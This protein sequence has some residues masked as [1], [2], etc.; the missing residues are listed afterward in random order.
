LAA[1]LRFRRERLTPPDVGLPM[2]GRRRP[3]GLRREE[4]AS[5]ASVSVTY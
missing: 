4:V 1:F 2:A 5:L 3:S